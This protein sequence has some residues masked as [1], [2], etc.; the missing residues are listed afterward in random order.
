MN[1][2]GRDRPAGFEVTRTLVVWCPDWPLVAA[3][4][5]NV[6]AAIVFAN[7][8]IACSSPARTHGVRRGL[9]RREAQGRC[10]EIEI[11]ERDDSRDARAF[12][13]VV[14]AIEAF[15]PGVEV[16]RPG[17]CSLPTLGPSRYFGG[18]TALAAKVAGA[19]HDAVGVDARVGIAD[20]PFAAG[21]AARATSTGAA[22]VVP[23]GDSA[24]FL[25]P[26]PVSA[27]E[28]PELADLLRRLGLRTLGAFA[29][30]AEADVT[31]RF[32]PD[33]VRA[34]RLAR[35][36]DERP[37]ALRTPP[38]DLGVAIELDPPAERADA[39]AF[40]ARALAHQLHADLAARGLACTRIAIEAETEHGEHRARLWRH[41]GA[42]SPAM[43]AERVRWQLDGW[44][45]DSTPD[46]RVTAGISLVRLSPD[47]VRPD[48]GRQS[49][50]WGGTAELDERVARALARVQGM[51]GPDG[52]TTAVLVGGRSPGEQVRMV[53]W[54]DSRDSASAHVSAK[55]QPAWPGRLPPPSP[56]TVPETPAPA[57]V[58]DARGQ[59]VSVS[60]RGFLTASPARLDGVPVVAWAGPWPAD[61]RWWDAAAHRRRARFQMQTSDGAAYLVTRETGR[62]WIEATY[63]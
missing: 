55:E 23:N 54:G 60:G 34:H 58:V 56:A 48:D 30:L 50:F 19:V 11:F 6:P 31:A 38:E 59:P 37:L 14:A 32:G 21:L 47:E 51:L 45:H 33:G 9:R 4:L 61:E 41:D 57:D 29:A 46:G 39:A 20:G 44:L 62:W 5:A 26:F 36:L 25:A 28:R 8:V 15:A 7:R 3:G 42:L 52:V 18:D 35:G 13:P 24:A 53:P 2:P 16:T 43:I 10:P 17:V 12:E 40:A 22:R 1:Q 49:G 63:D 27:L